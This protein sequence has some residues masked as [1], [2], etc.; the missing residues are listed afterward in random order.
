MTIRIENVT[1]RAAGNVILEDIHLNLEPGAHIGIVGPSGA[2]KSSLVGLVLGW[3][4]AASGR[5]LADGVPIE[6]ARLD[7]L[8]RETA[9]VDPQ[10]QL[11]NRTLFDNLRYGA[12]ADAALPLD[13]VLDAADL[14]SVLRKLPEGLQTSLGEGGALGEDT[15]RPARRQAGQDN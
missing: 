13:E 10:V 3:H 5:V 4:R 6:G 11:W 9:W 7:Q 15:R 8:R 12:P 14:F 2:G 1:V